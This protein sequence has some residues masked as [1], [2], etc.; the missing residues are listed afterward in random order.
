MLNRE[1]GHGHCNLV[2]VNF[3][4][5]FLDTF[6]RHQCEA[7][8]CGSPWGESHTLHVKAPRSVTPLQA[9][10]G[11][12]GVRRNFR[13][14]SRWYLPPKLTAILF[15]K[16]ATP[17]PKR[18]VYLVFQASIF[19]VLLLLVSGTVFQFLGSQRQFQLTDDGLCFFVC[20]WACHV[21][22]NGQ[23]V[24]CQ[25]FRWFRLGTSIWTNVGTL[26]RLKVLWCIDCS[27]PIWREVQCR[28]HSWLKV[29]REMS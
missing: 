22:A 20:G 18:K 5:V 19:Q 27:L 9:Q 10:W 17:A 23:N 28:T 24:W 25:W 7:T 13:R 1:V 6:L 16:L 21:C 14:R 11:H 15:W 26:L 3:F 4:H 8:R 29:I 12:K 2:N